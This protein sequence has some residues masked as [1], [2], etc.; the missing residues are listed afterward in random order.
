[1]Q[2]K[3][4]FIIL[5]LFGIISL[6][7]GITTWHLK[8][9]EKSLSVVGFPKF[10]ELKPEQLQEILQSIKGEKPTKISYRE[11]ISPD[12]KLKLFYLS[13]W[14]EIKDE[15]ILEKTTPLERV[16]KYGQKTLLLAQKLRKEKIAQLIISELNLDKQ[17]NFEDIIEE[18]KEVNHQQGW[19]MEIIKSEIKGSEDVF[20]AKY[21]KQ[22]RYDTHSK[23]KII[24]LEPEGEKRKV[25][26]IAVIT[27]DRDWQEFAE[28][29]EE[30]I[31][32]VQL[33][34]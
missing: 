4:I 27:L 23:E 26:S 12:G 34:K 33:I 13:D 21:R 30:I 24:L 8:K 19:E 28:E 31:N 2:K 15:K 3:I 1:M 10:E 29:A 16:E 9:I 14:I 11:F 17:K 20:E 7:T 32:S 25:Y 5:G 18:M 22:D 6:L